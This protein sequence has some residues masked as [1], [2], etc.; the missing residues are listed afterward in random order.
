MTNEQIDQIREAAHKYADANLAVNAGIVPL[1]KAFASGAA[2]MQEQMRWRKIWK[3]PPPENIPIQCYDEPMGV[4][5]DI[6]L[7]KDNGIMCFQKLSIP[8][9][10]TYLPQPPTQ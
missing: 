1:C 5:N 7:G 4:Y 10:W 6:Y 3:E 9:H 8:S 2:W